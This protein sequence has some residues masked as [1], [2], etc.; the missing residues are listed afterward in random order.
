MKKI[1]RIQN[2]KE[3]ESDYSFWKSVSPQERINAIEI[4][5]S[6]YFQLNKNVQQRLQRVYTI[7]KRTSS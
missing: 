2:R 3:S 4:L 5:R 7:T 6:Q 1:I